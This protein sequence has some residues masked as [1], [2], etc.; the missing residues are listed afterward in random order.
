M[1][2]NEKFNLIVAIVD[3]GFTDLVM[4]AAR[5]HGARGGTVL[6]ARGT[7]NKE[8]E[9]KFGIIINSEKEMVFILVNEKICDDI[10]KAINEAAGL[11]TKGRGIAFSLPCEDVC[12]LKFE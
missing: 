8:I 5:D 10:L 4:D 6:H 1:E 7:G 9:E 11:N 3:A 2:N 12:G